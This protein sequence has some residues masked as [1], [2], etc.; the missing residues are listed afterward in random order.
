MSAETS[1]ALT[2]GEMARRIGCP[3]HRVRYVIL[4]R[5]ITPTAWAG[6]ARIFSPEDFERI[7]A[8]VRRIDGGRGHVSE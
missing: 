3:V 4:S 7:A 1:Q 2:V 8:E 5:G 6:V